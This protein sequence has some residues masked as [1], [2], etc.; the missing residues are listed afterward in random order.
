MGL[1]D[2]TPLERPIAD[3]ESVDAPTGG[4]GQPGESAAA[5]KQLPPL[6]VRR[7]RRRG[8]WSAV[9]T[10]LEADA[11]ASKALLK[12][13]KADLGCGGGLSGDGSIVLQGD[14]RDAVLAKL[15]DRGH[16]AKAAGG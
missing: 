13:L 9:V 15:L 3:E 1:F 2:G 11:A 16:A 6:R 7:E 5:D 10:G 14:C 8:K 4:D 12:E